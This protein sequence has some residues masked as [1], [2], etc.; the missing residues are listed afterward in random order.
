[1]GCHGSNTLCDNGHI[2]LRWILRKA[3][4]YAALRDGMPR[5]SGLGTEEVRVAGTTLMLL[6]GAGAVLIG[7]LIE[8]TR[9]VVR[10]APEAL[11]VLGAAFAL[12]LARKSHG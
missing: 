6:M 10:Q 12:A 9:E 4:R 2:P 8:G 11:L 1:M 3:R 7:A 5:A